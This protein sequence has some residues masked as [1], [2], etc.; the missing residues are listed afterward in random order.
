MSLLEHAE[1]EMKLVGLD[2]EDS[3]YN[4]MIYDAVMKMMK[5]FADEGHS[6]FSAMKVLAVFDRLAKFKPLSP[7]TN[8][9]K[10]WNDV[11]EM[12]GG[13]PMWQNNRDSECFSKDCGK[14]Y[15]C[16]GDREKIITAKNKE[17]K[18]G[19]KEN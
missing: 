1:R 18:N 11:S 4:G 10:E 5:V 6:G 14:T 8:D 13:N 15:Y 2:K 3:E 12:S 17:E 19:C 16:L 7:L 9:P